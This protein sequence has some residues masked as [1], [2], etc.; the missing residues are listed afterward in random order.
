MHWEQRSLHSLQEEPLCCCIGTS[1]RECTWTEEGE[2]SGSGSSRP[3]WGSLQKTKAS[4]L[5]GTRRPLTA[6]A[7]GPGGKNREALNPCSPPA[8]SLWK[9]AAADGVQM[10]PITRCSCSI[11]KTTTAPQLW[12]EGTRS[13][14]GEEMQLGYV[15][16]PSIL[17]QEH[18]G[19]REACARSPLALTFS[20]EVCSILGR[21]ETC[22]S[23]HR[24]RD[25]LSQLT[26]PWAS[27]SPTLQL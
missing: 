2:D 21:T 12:S 8:S 24:T 9:Q 27:S 13:T 15:Q 16:L 26:R 19:S 22:S 18:A 20:S 10:F 5:Q 7:P 6:T 17:P 4:S 23:K 25:A 11:Q 1:P 3:P 14:E